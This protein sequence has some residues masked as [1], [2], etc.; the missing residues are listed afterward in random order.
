MRNIQTFFSLLLTCFFFQWGMNVCAASDVHLK[1]LRSGTDAS[2]VQVLVQDGK[3][4][5][6]NGVA[7]K[8][9]SS[10]NFRATQ[11]SITEQILC[12]DANGNTSPNIKLDFEISNLPKGTAF[13]QVG[14][15]LHALSGGNAYQENNDGKQRQFNVKVSTGTDA[16]TLS[17]FGT[18][19][20]IDIAKGVGTSG[21]VHQI[22]K[23]DGTN[24]NCTSNK[25][26]VS[27]EITKGTTNEGCFIGLSEIILTD[28][29]EVVPPTPTPDP[30]PE[31]EP[32]K[33]GLTAGIYNIVW[34]NNTTSYMAEEPDGSMVI[35]DYDVT[36]RIFWE[37]VPSEKHKGCYYIKNTASGKYIGSC[38]KEPNSTSK[39][40]T[41]KDPVEYYIGLSAST[42]GENVGCH[43]L[44]STDCPNYGSENKGPKALNK[45][46]DSKN[47]ITWTAGVGNKGSYWKMVKTEDLYDVRP[48]MLSEEVGKPL[49]TY[50]ITSSK[51]KALEMNADRKLTWKERNESQEQT[52]YFVSAANNAGGY[53]IVNR[54]DHR[55]L[56]NGNEENARWAAV[57]N[58]EGVGYQF[59]PFSTKD[60]STTT[61]TVEGESVIRFHLSHTDFA[62]RYQVYEL[63]CGTLADR[64]VVQ[65][66][67]K[68]DVIKPMMYPMAY[69]NKSDIIVPKASRPSSWYSFFTQDQ[70]MVAAGKKFDVNISLNATP[71]KGQEGF[72]YFDWNRDGIFETTYN[73]NLAQENRIEVTVPDFVENG[74][75]RM[76]FRLTENG[77][78]GAEDEVIGQIIDWVV[79]TVKEAPA[80]NT[81]NVQINDA[82]RGTVNIKENG[83]NGGACHLEALPKGNAKF[84]CWREGRNVVSLDADYRFEL[85]HPTT[86]IACFSPNT[87]GDKPS[88]I[89]ENGSVSS[90]LIQVVAANKQIKV[91]TAAP[92][93]EVMVFESTGRMIAHSN[94]PVVNIGNCGSDVLIVK[95]YTETQDKSVKVLLR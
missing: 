36:Q 4:G 63:P 78:N 15:D 5:T 53:L 11:G 45:D 51:G 43:Y 83:E 64:Y 75:T 14:L 88:G 58:Q 82:S 95:V 72:L 62:R 37:L 69:I 12:P 29:K 93:K 49:Y 60:D 80:T 84:V 65:A 25:L 87:E 18:L 54:K 91:T 59:R 77:L 57:D 52:W 89:Q 22:W 79:N 68:G 28:S 16:Q 26:T 47:I 76:R 55:V 38:N 33:N 40:S 94:Q 81:L 6:I 9:Q 35:K 42:S 1:F 74:K 39:I 34:K 8:V 85:N 61:L 20:N 71:L 23:L 27:L 21:N 10:K 7:V 46:G 13:N 2:Q 19:A 3:G 66:R 70:A 73:V 32:D 90:C 48:F 92:L 56:A 86:L 24:V 17:E 41:S 31:P 50:S 30:E 67:V 44:S